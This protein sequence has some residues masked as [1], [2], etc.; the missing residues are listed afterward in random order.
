MH[1]DSQNG[2]RKAQ[3][4]MRG[5]VEYYFLL[6]VLCG[7]GGL[8]SG[9]GRGSGSGSQ[10]SGSA[11]CGLRRTRSSGLSSGL[12]SGSGD[13]SGSCSPPC[14]NPPCLLGLVLVL[15]PGLVLVLG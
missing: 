3:K 10:G 7:G 13:G 12:S 2:D 1:P 4:R 14:T 15:V 5:H 9:S 11:S 6:G 8:S